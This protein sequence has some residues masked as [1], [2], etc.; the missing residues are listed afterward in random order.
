MTFMASSLNVALPSIGHEFNADAIMLSWI[1]TVLLLGT[2]VLSVPFS[3]I[4][5]IVGIKKIFIYGMFIFTAGMI[6]SALSSSATM[7]LISRIVQGIGGAMIVTTGL[8]LIP[9]V[10][11]A[12]ERGVALGIN[13]TFVYLGS[14]VGPFAGGILTEHFGWRS[15]FL[16]A[17]I[18]SVFAILL[19]FWKIKS[20]WCPSRGEKFD[21]GGSLFY[22]LA[23]VILM[24]GFST[25]PK[26]TG[27]ILIAVGIL[28]LIFFFRWESRIKSPLLNVSVLKNNRPFIFS[29]VASLISY[30]AVFAITF[31]LS[32]Y[33]QYI[34]ALTPEQA[35]FVMM[36]QP[37]MQALLST[38]SGRLSDRIQPRIVASIG[39]ALIFIGLLSFIFL[40]ND[41]SLVQI[42]VTL[43]ILGTGFALFSSPNVNAIMSSVAPQYYAVATAISHTGRSI[44]QMLS[45]GIAMIVIAIVIGPVVITPNY[46]PAFLTS[47]KICFLIFTLLCFGGIFASLSRG[48]IK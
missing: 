9:A 34:K 15:I 7:L 47:A 42:I 26:V 37:V 24:Y 4:A 40:S 28:G 45:M 43:V 14:S 35:G 48:K 29:N 1:V 18:L 46:Y 33:L 30:T 3:R 13:I 17:I 38:F 44:G 19:I 12:N 27:Y 41:T 21:F 20:E 32:L 11:P 25:L 31:L 6:V 22:G 23:L 8:S 39:M 36:V 2:A 16:V 5:S 10:Y